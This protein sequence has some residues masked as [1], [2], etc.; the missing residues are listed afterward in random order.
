MPSLQSILVDIVRDFCAAHELMRRVSERFRSGELGFEEL[1]ALVGDDEGSV[2][3]RLKERCHALFRPAEPEAEMVSPREALFDLAVGSLF[4][5]AMKFRENFYQREVYGPRVRALRREADPDAEPFFHEFERILE[6]V[7]SRLEE[8][9]EET[10][11]LMAQTGAQLRV[12][13]ANQ[14]HSGFVLRY[15]IENEGTAVSVFGEDFDAL[16]AGLHGDTAS[17]FELAGRS[18]LDSGYFDA[19]DGAFAAAVARGG[20]RDTL[21]PLCDYA[22]GMAA[23]LGGDYRACIERLTAWTDAGA[24][25]PSLADLAHGAVSRIGP[26]AESD[27]ERDALAELSGGLLARLEPALSSAT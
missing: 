9:L 5:E 24:I 23:F 22:R 4:H 25:Q 3:F 21:L 2:L 20:E 7:S 6:A 16:L 1:Q 12:L 18:Y 13:L 11:I 27:A 15:L 10:E 8:G 26:L 17:A 14:E 19:A